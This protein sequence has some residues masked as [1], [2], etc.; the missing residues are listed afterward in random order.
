MCW[1]ARR[2]SKVHMLL[3]PHCR[4]SLSQRN[5]E[6]P[7]ASSPGLSDLKQ[8]RQ[9]DLSNN[10]LSGSIPDLSLPRLETYLLHG[11]QLS[12]GLPSMKELGRLQNATLHD[13]QLTGG[14]LLSVRTVCSA[15]L[16]RLLPCGM[17]RAAA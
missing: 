15:W 16:R 10:R 9:L 1:V 2:R 3:L 17:P 5:L 4:L 13:N 12:G 6:G 7:I 11:N 8:L 14:Q